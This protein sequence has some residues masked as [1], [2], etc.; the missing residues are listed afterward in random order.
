MPTCRELGIGNRG[1][2]VEVGYV[3]AMS[4]LCDW[5]LEIGE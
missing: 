3:A 2:R 1:K 4:L 5:E